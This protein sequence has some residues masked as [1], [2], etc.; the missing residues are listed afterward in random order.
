MRSSTTGVS[1]RSASTQVTENRFQVELLE[2]RT[3]LA[4]QILSFDIDALRSH[5][6]VSGYFEF[7]G[8]AYP[9]ITA[10]GGNSLTSKLDGF[11]YAE[12]TDDSIS[13]GSG[14][15]L[16][17]NELL[18]GDGLPRRFQPGLPGSNN[19]A[20]ADFAARLDIFGNIANLAIRNFVLDVHSGSAALD[21]SG[22]F[23]SN[24]NFTVDSGTFDFAFVTFRVS[25]NISGGSIGNTPGQSGNLAFLSGDSAEV[26][27]PIDISITE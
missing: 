1:A 2:D 27:L 26:D 6:S 17:A 22:N 25:V 23:S 16:D 4:A 21:A 9:F 24:L 8:N 18:R 5:L 14:S 20:P 19:A 10:T 11:L 7:G 15:Y 12:V 13:F 3:L